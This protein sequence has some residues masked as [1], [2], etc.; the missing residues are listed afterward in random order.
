MTA[1]WKKSVRGIHLL[2]DHTRKTAI[3]GFVEMY[4]YSERFK[5]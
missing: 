3:E 5:D 1:I 4:T 2:F